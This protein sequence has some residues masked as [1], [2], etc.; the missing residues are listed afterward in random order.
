MNEF[1]NEEEDFQDEFESTLDIGKED[2][3]PISTKRPRLSTI[4]KKK[5]FLESLDK[6]HGVIAPACI[7]AGI[8][9][10]TF[11]RWRDS[12]KDFALACEQISENA[13]DFVETK[14]YKN[15]ENGKEISTIFYL[16]TKAKHR[17][18]VE[19]TQLDITSGG[20]PIVFQFGSIAQP[21][22]TIRIEESNEND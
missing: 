1:I 19:G 17:G 6:N 12:D 5:I 22:P 9:R 15:I 16:K 14:L 7:V 2:I 8:N 18:Y 13:I 20:E 11:H 4:K 3:V 21:Q 10:M